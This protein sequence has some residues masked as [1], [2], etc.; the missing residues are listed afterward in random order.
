MGIDNEFK[1][2]W[3]KIDELIEIVKEKTADMDKP[4][5]LSAIGTV[6]KL[7]SFKHNIPMRDFVTEFAVGI[8]RAENMFSGFGVSDEED[9]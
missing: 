9:D 4:V 1:N 6:M 3:K 5:F 7:Y 8:F 2:E